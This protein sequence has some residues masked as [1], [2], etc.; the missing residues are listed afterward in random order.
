MNEL[1]YLKPPAN[2]PALEADTQAIGFGMG[3]D[4]RT[5]ALLRVLAASKRNARLL[6]LGTGTGL[7]TAW[8]LDGMD[9]ASQLD[10]V[11]TD[12]HC[13]EIARRHLGHDAR[14]RFHLADGATF[15]AQA[16]PASY[17]LIFADAWPGKFSELDVA[18]T[19]L[20]PG[21]F[22]VIDDLLPQPNW[23]EGHAPKVPR[24]IETLAQHP[25]LRLCPLAWSSGLV[26]AVKL[27]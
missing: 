23:P 3:S 22:Y 1:D 9:T 19:L 15:L 16:A 11:D 17:D 4:A 12:E 25:A 21:G 27:G 8:L 14:V 6:E 5:G 18:L 13:V 26:I 10:T 24:L 7:A 20:K 2:L